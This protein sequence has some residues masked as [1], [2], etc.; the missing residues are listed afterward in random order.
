M[1]KTQVKKR[2]PGPGGKRWICP[3]LRSMFF[4][5]L[6]AQF[7]CACS[8]VPEPQVPGPQKNRPSDQGLLDLMEKK[9]APAGRENAQPDISTLPPL[10]DLAPEPVMDESSA[11]EDQLFS[12]SVR[13]VP[14]R[15][16]LI[17]LVKQAK[18]N[19]VL[20][21]NV[22]GEELISVEF[23]RLPLRR[24]M[25]EILQTFEYAHELSGSILRIKAVDTRVLHF[26]YPLIF[27]TSESDVGGDM[28]GSSGGDSGNSDLSAEFSVETS[29][30]DN[31]SLNI[32]KQVKAILQPRPETNESRPG[33]ILGILSEI[34]RATVDSASG[35]IVVTD[36][37]HILDRVEMVLDNM[38][39]SLGRQVVIEA[40]IIEVELNH[41]HQYGID[42][43]AVRSGG[44]FGFDMASNLASDL[45][46]GTGTFEL[47]LSSLGN[48]WT[49]ASTIDA[50][51][52]QGDVNAISSP[53]LNVINNQSATI[54]IGRTIPYLD[55]EISSVTSGDT[56]SYEAVPTVQKA[57]AGV[58]L[59]ITP[60]IGADDIITLSIV[61]VITDQDGEQSFT[62]DGTT[63]AV[64][65]LD[66][67]SASTIIS[68]ADG[69]TIVLGGMIQDINVDNRTKVPLLGDIPLLGTMLF[70]NQAKRNKKVELVILLT[71]RIV[72]R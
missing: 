61:P 4:M 32:W 15:D 33:E 45:A 42:W 13:S 23:D 3:V 5:L 2:Q 35:T 39:E 58:S 34:G 40:K 47:N 50:I 12:L 70:S 60:R 72:R 41:T 26:D 18:L 16:V 68:A 57:Q 6:C 71:P 53:R 46:S 9:S 38:K 8:V 27:N 43:S 62:Y 25:E 69:E 29:L 37:P 10:A 52:T 21:P 64:P 63:W 66:T 24:A 65:I 67:R 59:G 55:F 31:D 54:S 20:G 51:A 49:L 1:L 44:K 36:R 56:V 14:L 30:E 17:G 7:I 28:L 11:F 48:E 22:D 19:L